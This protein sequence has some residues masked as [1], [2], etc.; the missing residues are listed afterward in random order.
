MTTQP[1]HTPSFHRRSRLALVRDFL[2]AGLA[3]L[4]VAGFL[5]D[6]AGGARPSHRLAPRTATLSS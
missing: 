1:S 3:V 4:V 5:I 6:V 2:V